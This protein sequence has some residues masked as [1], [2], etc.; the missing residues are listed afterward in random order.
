MGFITI[1][2][3]IAMGIGYIVLLIVIMFTVW[4]FIETIKDKKRKK[5]WERENA[6]KKKAESIIAK[7]NVPSATSK[8][9]SARSAAT[10][11]TIHQTSPTQLSGTKIIPQETATN[12]SKNEE[13]KSAEKDVNQNKEKLVDESGKLKIVD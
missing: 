1:L 3:Y 2:N 11:D 7:E 9:I 12:P 5:K 4:F 6:D 13:S 10:I 8:P